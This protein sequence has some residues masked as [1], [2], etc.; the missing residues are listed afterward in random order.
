MKKAIE[1]MKKGKASGC[2]SLP[3]D[4]VKHLGQSGVDMMREILKGVWEE[5]QMPE[6]WEK[7]E[8]VP[9]YK[10]KGDPLES[11]NFRGI[12]LLEHGM[13]MLEK[14]LERRLRKL[15]TVNN[16]QSGFSPGKGT[17]DAVFIIQ[18]L[19]EKHLE[20]YKDL[21]LT[22]VDLEK[23]YDRV[24]RDLVYWCLRRR[25]VPEKPVRL[26]EATY[27]GAS[28]VV[29]TTHDRT[30]EFPIKVG[31]HQ[32][33][34]LSPFLFII[35]LDVISEESRCGLPRELLFTDDLAVVTDTEEEMQM[36]WLGWQ[37]GMESKGLKVNIGKTE[38]MVSSRRGT[39]VNIKDSQGTSL[40]QVN[41]FKYLGV[42]ISEEGGSEEAVRARV[43]AAW[44]K[45]R[46]I[47][48]VISDKKMPKKLKI[49]LYM[50]VIRP[51]LL[52]GA[53]CWTVRRKEE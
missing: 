2:S 50:T 17:T 8:I 28:T 18:Q 39:K 37:I 5:G 46:D 24:P 36:R 7:S 13:K 19:Q 21:F 25:G 53:E 48:G 30:N 20:V 38:V 42:T 41:K 52:Y 12:K 23:A 47:S 10:Q 49:M 11:G 3:T 51:V 16:M 40:R 44:G 32:G 29:R 33:S 35:V 27:R 43:S 26:V 14:L 9:I 45:W 4:L 1:R 34:G 6:E 22:F 15:V 31:L